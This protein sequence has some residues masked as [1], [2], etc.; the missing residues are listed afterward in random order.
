MAEPPDIPA[1]RPVTA[2]RAAGHRVQRWLAERLSAVP[3]AEFELVRAE[4]ERMRAGRDH[5]QRLLGLVF[6]RSSDGLVLCGSQGE[7]ASCNAAAAQLL[8]EAPSALAGQRLQLRIAPPAGA[9]APAKLRDGE[10]QLRRPDAS[11]VPVDLAIAKVSG[12]RRQQYLVRIRDLGDRR[13]AED[14]LQQLAQYDSLTG[15]PNRTLFRARLERAMARTRHTGRTMALMLFDIDRFKSVNDSLGQEVGDLLLKHVAQLLS[16]CLQRNDSVTRAGDDDGFTVS[17]LGGDEFTV[18]AESI[19]GDEDASLIAQRVLDGLSVPFKAAGEE[20]VVS[21]SIGITT[22]TG[23]DTDL[24]GLVRRTDLAMHRAKSLGRGLYCFYSDE[25]RASASARLLLEGSLRR[26]LERSEFVL[27]FQPKADLADGQVSGVEALVRW[28]C[29]GRGLVSPDRFIGVLEDT[30]LILPVGAWV[31]R[32]AIAQL[33]EWDR[34]GL[35]HLRVAVN[36]SARQFRHQQLATM[37]ADTLREHGIAASRV[38]LELTESMLMEDTEAT[39]T[40]LARFRRLGLR[41]ALD[42]FG[43]GHSSLAYLKRF[44]LQT[45]KIDRSFV[46][47]LP[48]NFEDTAIARAVIALGRTMNMSVVAEGVETAVQA[49]AL[50]DMGCDEIQG[51]LLSRPLDA[52]DFARWLGKR[53]ER[54]RQAQRARIDPV[55]LPLVDIVVDDGEVWGNTSPLELSTWNFKPQRPPSVEWTDEPDAGE[56][57]TARGAEPRADGGRDAAGAAGA[58]AGGGGLGQDPGADHEDRV[59]AGPGAGRPGAGVRRHVHEQG[60]QGDADAAVGHAAGERARHVDRHLPRPCQPLPA[61]A[62]EAGRAAAELPDP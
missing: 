16:R 31:F 30:G 38:E 34:Q 36:V 52:A 41:L 48:N 33:A 27:Y 12:D 25:L 7:I 11:L 35:P 23:D 29:P 24:E 40:T 28:H 54:T 37:M 13:R 47:A 14:R 22:Y 1:A 49:N 9:A 19:A 43:T 45:L 55:R 17:R 21:A 15:L 5:L 56:R 10:A 6:E 59:A 46:N 44:N 51:Y 58:G 60:R 39:R 3:R 20:V 4:F 2:A 50:R 62:L 26:A 42:D 53:L 8:G 61:G 32:A 57:A 18:I